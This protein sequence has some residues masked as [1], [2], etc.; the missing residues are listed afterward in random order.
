MTPIFTSEALIPIGNLLPIQTEQANQKTFVVF[1][2][3]TE[4][5]SGGLSPSDITPGLV[6]GKS[7]FPKQW[8]A[9][10]KQ[11]VL[12]KW[13]TVS[14]TSLEPQSFPPPFSDDRTLGPLFVRTYT[15]SNTL[16]IRQKT[17][18]S[19]SFFLAAKQITSTSSGQTPESKG[20]DFRVTKP[21][22]MAFQPDRS[23]R[24]GIT[25]SVT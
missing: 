4:P 17:T 13:S 12:S 24:P 22:G 5:H 7:F 8:E 25:T 6:P 1:H 15:R 3:F 21:K 2:L 11:G 23:V 14:S 19:S 9:A 10:Y 18:F 16:W 20:I